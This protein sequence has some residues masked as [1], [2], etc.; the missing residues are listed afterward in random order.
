M[1]VARL[2][3]CAEVAKRNG[4]TF[5]RIG[6]VVYVNGTACVNLLQI[7]EVLT[8]TIHAQRTINVL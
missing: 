7:V 2:E 5:V 6:P 3:I 1:N 4:I 8:A